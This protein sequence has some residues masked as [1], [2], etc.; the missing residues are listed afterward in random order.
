MGSFDSRAAVT[1][2]WPDYDWSAAEA[3]GGAFHDVLVI[4]DTVVAKVSVPLSSPTDSYG[5]AQARV[6]PASAG[7]SVDCSRSPQAAVGTD[8]GCDHTAKPAFGDRSVGHRECLLWAQGCSGCSD[9]LKVA[10][11]HL[12]NDVDM[13]ASEVATAVARKGV[14]VSIPRPT[15]SVEAEIYT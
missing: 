2:E 15:S 7:R 4:A 12:S 6:C 10:C 8:C 13:R 11:D 9:Y 14:R 1:A 3:R 5:P